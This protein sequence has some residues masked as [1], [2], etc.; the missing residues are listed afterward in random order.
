MAFKAITFSVPASTITSLPITAGDYQ[1]GQS[2]LIENVG[3]ANLSIG[4]SDVNAT[5][6]GFPFPIGRSLPVT[7]DDDEVPC[8]WGTS[9]GTVSV[10]AQGV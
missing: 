6:K 8:F 9:T 5:D 2:L 1:A 7:I 10:L 4:G 3:S